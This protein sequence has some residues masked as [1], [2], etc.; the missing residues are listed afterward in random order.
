MAF[1]VE[2]QH[3][4]DCYATDKIQLDLSLWRFIVGGH[5]PIAA[6][7]ICYFSTCKA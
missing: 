1:I 7:K 5:A 3:K 6:S 2:I 4:Q